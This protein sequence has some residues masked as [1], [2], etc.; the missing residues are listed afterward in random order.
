MNR[1][2]VDFLSVRKWRGCILL[3]GIL[4]FPLNF[5]AQEY[6]HYPDSL[7]PPYYHQRASQF[8]LMPQLQPDVVFLGNSITDGGNWAELF[9]ELKVFNRGISGDITKGVLNRLGETVDRHPRKLFLLIGTNDLAQG[10]DKD[11]VLNR[12]RQIIS[13]IRTHSPQTEIYVQSIFPVNAEPHRFLGHAKNTEKI[14]Y[15][16]HQLQKEAEKNGYTYIDLFTALKNEEG[17]MDL[18]YSNDGLHL[19]GK[20]YMLWKHLIYPYVFDVSEKPSIVP[21]PQEL[22]WNDQKFPLYQHPL[23][24]VRD[25]VLEKEAKLLKQ[26]LNTRGVDVEISALHEGQRPTIELCIG[27]V[28]APQISE[29]AYSL[30]VTDDKVTIEGNTPHGVFNG[31]QTFLQLARDGTFAEGIEINDWPAFSYRGYLVDVGRNYQSIAQLKEQLEVMARYKLNR[32]HFHPTEDIAW[33]LQIKHYPELTKGEFMTRDKGLYY[34]IDQV[35]ELQQF[36]ADRHI[37]LILEVDM[38]GHSEAFKR[39]TGVDMQSTKGK[40]ILKNILKE[41]DTTYHPTYIHIGADEVEIKDT[42]FIPEMVDV[43]HER[44]IETIGWA[45]GGNYDDRTIRQLWM[46]ESIEEGAPLRYIDSRALYLNH[47]DPLSGVFS[48]FNRRIGDVE[49]GNEQVIGGE[50]AIWNDVRVKKEEDNLQMNFAYPG[51]VAF[52]ERAWRGG[53]EEGS[54]TDIGTRESKRRKDFM[55]FE[56]RLLDQKRTFFRT[57]SFPYTRQADMDWKLFGPFENKGNLTAPFWPEETPERLSEET[58]D[59]EAHGATVWL[60]HFF[61]PVVAG[62][63][64]SPEENTTWYAYREIYSRV[65]TTAH[66]WIGFN[67]PS[68]SYATTTP[69]RGEWDDRG[70]KVWVNGKEVDPP[71]WTY[72]G[73]DG[74]Q[75]DPLVEE[76][77]EYRE[78]TSMELKKGVNTILI[79]AP[80]GSFRGRSWQHPVKWMFT[81]VRV[82]E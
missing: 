17:H 25:S 51:I 44:G 1:D 76:S 29:E 60:R 58:P 40:E 26:E 65:E 8:K 53:G 11:D 12:I 73:R 80:V 38:P 32:F 3:L 10:D 54:L 61:D 33:R 56:S 6:P 15:I 63:L 28:K 46:S 43:L 59:S 2:R 74:T 37:E 55:E 45:P 64:E 7:F 50:I 70:S 48:V 35:K 36:A 67:N 21:K 52:G 75:E 20:G 39:A 81:M 77:Y 22:Q 18:S 5:N 14:K 71:K 16:N 30:Q 27:S 72:P 42:T 57:K 4:L 49:K 68:R 9:P 13:L 66:F 34:T 24:L 82:E 31:I 62:A 78:P 47:M 69:E 41:V 19:L 79:K 23:I